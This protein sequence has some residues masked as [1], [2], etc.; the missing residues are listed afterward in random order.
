MKK[1]KLSGRKIKL[2]GSVKDKVEWKKEQVRRE[3]WKKEV[4]W[5][6]DKVRRKGC[7]RKS[8][9]REEES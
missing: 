6:K 5:V 1:E 4:E 3:R 9:V 7:T 8:W 2:E